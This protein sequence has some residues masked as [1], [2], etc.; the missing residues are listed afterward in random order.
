MPS[1]LLALALLLVPAPARASKLVLTG[2]SQDHSQAI[3]R[4]LRL[5]SGASPLRKI[6]WRLKST[7]T[8]WLRVSWIKTQLLNRE[9]TTIPQNRI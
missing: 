4:S 7:I 3:W 5:S 8:A 6:R 1:R 2:A 9:R